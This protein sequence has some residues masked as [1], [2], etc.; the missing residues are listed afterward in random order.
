MSET[1]TIA[2]I[3][4]LSYSE[5]YAFGEV[6]DL[7]GNFETSKDMLSYFSIISNTVPVNSALVTYYEG[8]YSQWL[9]LDSPTVDSTNWSEFVAYINDNVYVAV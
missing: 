3:T 5:F 7:A 8:L 4:S 2:G 1:Q 9:T 6:L